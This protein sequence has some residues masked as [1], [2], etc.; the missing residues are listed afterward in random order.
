MNRPADLGYPHPGFPFRHDGVPP[1]H[2]PANDGIFHE[3]NHPLFLGGYAESME[4]PQIIIM[5]L[6]SHHMKN[7]HLIFDQIPS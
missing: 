1:S 5:C 3:I 7:Y 6:E 4:P 2:H